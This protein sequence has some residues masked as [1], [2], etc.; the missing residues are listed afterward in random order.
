[1]PEVCEITVTAQFIMSRV[2]N[3]FIESINIVSGRYTHQK[4]QNID[5]IRKYS[6]LDNK[7]KFMWFEL[8]SKKHN[9]HVYIMNTF[10]LSGSWG[11]DNTN[12]TRVSISIIDNKKKHIDDLYFNDGRNFGT[13]KITEKL[14]E[15][16]EKLDKLAPDLLKTEY[17]LN[18]YSVFNK[19]GASLSTG[20][21]KSFEF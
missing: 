16:H 9:K 6:P 18:E 12:S 4:L 10:G 11:F 17:S 5:L 14:E 19:S 1:M 3:K 2:K 13:I 8:Y 7:G 21:E 15:L 20:I